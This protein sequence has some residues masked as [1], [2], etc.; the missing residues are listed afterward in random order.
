MLEDLFQVYRMIRALHRVNTLLLAS[1]DNHCSWRRFTVVVAHVKLASGPVCGFGTGTA[2]LSTL[3]A[4]ALSSN[5][6]KDGE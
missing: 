1:E 3:I 2:L 4:S 5:G 6:C